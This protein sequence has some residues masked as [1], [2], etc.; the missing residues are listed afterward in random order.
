MLLQK[1]PGL[2]LASVLVDSQQAIIPAPGD[3]TPSF[4]PRKTYIHMHI[5]TQ[6]YPIIFSKLNSLLSS[7]VIAFI[8][9]SLRHMFFITYVLL[10]SRDA[11]LVF[12]KWFIL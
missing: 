11:L 5:H 10:N 9:P 12:L 1:T 7:I 8:F 3:L 2:F 4:D 6:M